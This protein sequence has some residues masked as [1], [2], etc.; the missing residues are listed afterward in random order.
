MSDL[1]SFFTCES[2][3]V[4]NFVVVVFSPGSFFLQVGGIEIISVKA[5]KVVDDFSNRIRQRRQQCKFILV[6][7]NVSGQMAASVVGLSSFSPL[8]PFKIS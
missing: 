1:H 2:T 7:R 3:L 5:T 4:K 8:L 6:A